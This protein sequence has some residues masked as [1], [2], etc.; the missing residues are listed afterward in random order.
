MKYDD[1][2]WCVVVGFLVQLV[3]FV[4]FVVQLDVH[5]VVY[6]VVHAVVHVVHVFIKPLLFKCHNKIT[7]EYF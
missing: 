1:F 4:V 6:V 5:A 7:T 3:V 2:F